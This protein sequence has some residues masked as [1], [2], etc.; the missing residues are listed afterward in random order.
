MVSKTSSTII[1]VCPFPKDG[2]KHGY[3]TGVGSYMHN[4]AYAFLEPTA[5]IS[6]FY[7]EKGDGAQE[8]KLEN[9][10]TVIRAWEKGTI[11]LIKL[12][13]RLFRERPKLIHIQHELSIFGGLLTS[14]LFP[15]LLTLFK[16]RSVPVVVTLHGVPNLND[17]TSTFVKES[18]YSIPAFAVRFIL[19]CIFTLIGWLSTKVI[20][21]EDKFKVILRE[22]YLQRSSKIIVIPHGIENVTRVTLELAQQVT[23]LQKV[24]FT[25]LY[26]GYLTGYK[27]VE[28]LVDG[29]EIFVKKCPDAQLIIGAGIHPKFKNDS[30]YLAEYTRI[31]EKAKKL[32]G[33]VW[34]GFIEEAQIPAYYSLADVCVFPYL[35]H[36]AGSGPMSLAIAYGCPVIASDAFE[37]ALQD[38]MLFKRTPEALADS[39]LK[40]LGDSNAGKSVISQYRDSRLW[41]A[42]AI[43]YVEVYSELM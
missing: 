33:V 6:T 4:L 21:H 32:P 42:V 24:S 22:Q 2:E 27:G 8:F 39:L 12:F 17:I 43:R 7:V 18:N 23:F 25:A 16:F 31:E 34:K 40:L 30:Q 29:W 41:P 26:M 14:V 13:V 1:H 28:M 38:E 5:S 19:R 11:G 36:L 35:Q 10:A 9:G 3:G 37:G 15:V 20:V